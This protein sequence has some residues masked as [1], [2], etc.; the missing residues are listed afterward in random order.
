MGCTSSSGGESEKEPNVGQTTEFT[1]NQTGGVQVHN[2]WANDTTSPRPMSDR[3]PVQ[4]PTQSPIKLFIAK[5]D[6]DAR[7]DEDLSFKKGELL[8]I[9]DD[10]CGDWWRARSRT[11]Q[12]EGYVPNN[13]I[14]EVKSL[15]AHE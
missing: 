11:S 14:A 3:P 1:A 13:F 12:K 2:Q 10:T 6:Y 4:P 9:L 15:E 8:E 5:Y 7:T